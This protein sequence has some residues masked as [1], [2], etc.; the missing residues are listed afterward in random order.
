M[1]I[2]GGGRKIGTPPLSMTPLSAR[3]VLAG[4]P[5]FTNEETEAQRG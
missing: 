1:G 4:D 2:G 3:V 5:H